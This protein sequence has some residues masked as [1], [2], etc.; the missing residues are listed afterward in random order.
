MY[1]R[2]IA[3]AII[4]ILGLVGT[5]AVAECSDDQ[6]AQAATIAATITKPAVSK[7]VAVTGKQMVSIDAC[8]SKDGNFLVEYKYNFLG[9]GGLYWV[10]ASAKFGPG[11]ASPSIRFTGK[12]PNLAAAEARS[13]LKLSAN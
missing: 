12:S 13:G 3:T 7:V 1:K 4:V 9:D 8:E 2:T 5:S 10:S 11:G 6:Q